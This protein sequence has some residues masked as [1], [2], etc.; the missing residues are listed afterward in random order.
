MHRMTPLQT[1][2]RAHAGGG[3]RV[4]VD[5]ANDGETMQEMKG[6]AMHGE[7][8]K[9]IESPQ[10]YGFSSVV[11]KAEKDKEGKITGSAEGFMSAV[12]G[13]SS[14]AYV[15]VM[16]DR[17]HRLKDLKPGDSGMFRGKN[18]RQQFHFAE[19]GTYMSARNDRKQR[20]ALV[21]PPKDDDQKQGGG[22]GGP[23]A[24][25][26]AAS[27]GGSSGGGGSGG[28]DG[29]DKKPTG[30]KPAMDDNKKSNVAIE[31]NGKETYSQHGKFYS[32][33]RSGSDS[34]TYYDNRKKSTQA[35]D[36]HVHMRFE[37]NKIWVD[38]SGHWSEGP[39]MQ[40]KDGHCKE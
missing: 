36:A 12:G 25:T 18:D 20:F 13:A 4:L 17:R 21:D 5:E 38:K 30:Q 3:K 8:R 22:G 15:G 32:S 1:G 31:Q 7:S 14:F 33:Q 19:D 34:S 6:T 35:T 16:D 39:I 24:T 27:S 10:N 11:A 37:G 9:N 40:R 2:F 28:K 23:T 26:T 29:G